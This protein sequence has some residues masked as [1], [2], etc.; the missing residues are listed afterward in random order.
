V[1]VFTIPIVFAIV[2]NAKITLTADYGKSIHFSTLIFLGVLDIYMFIYM[3][4]TSRER[5]N[6][7]TLTAD[8]GKSIL[9][10]TPKKSCGTRYSSYLSKTA[11]IFTQA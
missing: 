5:Q 9:F 3:R 6:R 4:N 2:K 10:T 11:F 8:Y 1:P 7:P